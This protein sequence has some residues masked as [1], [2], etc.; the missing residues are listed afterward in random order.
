M[1]P[2]QALGQP[3]DARSDVFSFGVVLYELL[4]GR[5]AF[6]GESEWSA[7]NAL[8]HDQ[9]TPLQDARPDVPEALA[10]IVDRCLEKDRARRY[11]SAVELL[12]DLRR[13]AP[14]S[15]TAT[16]V[17]DGSLPR[18]GRGGDAR[19]R[20]RGHVGHGRA[21][22]SRRRWSS[23]RCPKSSGWRASAS[24]STRI[25]SDSEPRPL[26]PAIR[27]CSGRSPLRRRLSP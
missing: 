6:D 8:V 13:L 9:P 22:G 12:D 18:C 14:A 2:E 20:D 17:A 19:G 26:R 24:T 5:R 21:D 27:A 10:Q 23:D 11:P 4:A 15:A 1:S 16:A 3:A 25:G 7:M